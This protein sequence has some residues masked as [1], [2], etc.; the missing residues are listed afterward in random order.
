MDGGKKN[1]S[2]IAEGVDEVNDEEVENFCA[3]LRSSREA[4]KRLVANA[5]KK[6]PSA[7]WTPKFILEDF[8][9]VKKEG[10]S[11]R[12]GEESEKGKK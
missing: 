9:E 12:Q 1:K 3:L 8:A 2:K 11:A 7:G 6:R 5:D 10:T 4:H